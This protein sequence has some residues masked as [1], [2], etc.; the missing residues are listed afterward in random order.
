M[1]VASIRRLVWDGKLHIVKLNRRVLVDLRD[2][3]RLI[4]EAKDRRSW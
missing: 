2:I 1:S 3:E 4:E